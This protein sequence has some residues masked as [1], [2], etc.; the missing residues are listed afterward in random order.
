[1]RQAVRPP[2]DHKLV[3]IV[4]AA[5]AGAARH[6]GEWLVCR[7]GC[8]QCCI[9]AFPI[10]QLD[11]ARLREGLSDLERKDPG[12]AIRVRSRSRDS[13]RRLSS[14]FPGNAKTGELDQSPLGQRKF[15]NF[16]NNEP[17][18]ALDPESGLCD[19]YEF[20]PMTC[21]VFGPPVRSENGIGVCELCFKGATDEEIAACEMKPDP[22]SMEDELLGQVESKS[23][24][25][26]QTIVA[27]CLAK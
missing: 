4:D 15:S 19:L 27:F 25:T 21:R 18:P 16:A 6:S 23:G 20:R 8:T 12:R 13:V 9:G 7:A 22:D 1:M 26:G 17:C 14:E 5:F 3:Q 11:A 10:N 24:K 2:A